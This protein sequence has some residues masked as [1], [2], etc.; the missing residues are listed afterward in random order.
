MLESNFPVDKGSCSYAALW[1]A[2][3]IIT[4]GASK[5]DRAALFAGTAARTDRLTPPPAV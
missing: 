1:N 4:R 3:K 5:A 2:F